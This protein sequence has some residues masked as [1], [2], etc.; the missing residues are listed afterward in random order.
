MLALWKMMA[1]LEKRIVI[2][3]VAGKIC[4]MMNIEIPVVRW[5]AVD[6]YKWLYYLLQISLSWS[7]M[8]MILVISQ[9]RRSGAALLHQ[10]LFIL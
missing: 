1:M 5:L 6:R 4:Q 9:V 3:K 8:P 10:C 2:G 7:W